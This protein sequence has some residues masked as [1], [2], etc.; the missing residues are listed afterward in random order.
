MFSEVERLDVMPGEGGLACRL[1][2][3]GYVAFGGTP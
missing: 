2:D 1:P 3:D